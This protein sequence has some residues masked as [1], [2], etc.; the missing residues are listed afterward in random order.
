MNTGKLINIEYL[1]H[2]PSNQDEH[3]YIPATLLKSRGRTGGKGKPQDKSSTRLQEL[4]LMNN[5]Y[6]GAIYYDNDLDMNLDYTVSRIFQ[7]MSLSELETLQNDR[8]QFLQSIALAVLKSPS[9]GY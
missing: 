8:A 3:S 5:T 1:T 4:S 6:F 2:H 9:A 7:G